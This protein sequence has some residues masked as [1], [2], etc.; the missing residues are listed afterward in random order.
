MKEIKPQIWDIL[1]A[2]EGYIQIKEHPGTSLYNC[3]KPKSKKLLLAARE[4]DEASFKDTNKLTNDAIKETVKSKKLE[5]HFQ[6]VA[7]T[8]LLD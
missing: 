3:W 5:W 7:I 6:C 8:L 2:P 1:Q 4:K